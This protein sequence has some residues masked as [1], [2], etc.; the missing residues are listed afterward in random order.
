MVFLHHKASC[1][2]AGA[3]HQPSRIIA[4]ISLSETELVVIDPRAQRLLIYAV[5]L[6]SRAEYPRSRGKFFLLLHVCIFCYH[7]KDRLKYSIIIGAHYIFPDPRVK[8]RFLK[9]SP[10]R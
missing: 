3:V 6:R 2:R 7:R 10:G 9:G 4:E 1:Q 8:K 5:F